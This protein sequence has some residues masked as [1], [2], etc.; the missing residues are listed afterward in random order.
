MECEEAKVRL[1][2]ELSGEL[3]KKDGESLLAHLNACRECSGEQEA[4]EWIWKE[5]EKIPDVG[6]PEG[7]RERTRSRIE[8]MLGHAPSR[9]WLRLPR[10]DWLKTPLNAVFGALAMAFL[11][12]W[13]L[14]GVTP[15]DELSAEVIFLCGA[16][17]AG[18]LAGSFLFAMGVLPAN[19]GRW[20]LASRIALTAFGLA[21]VGTL[22]CPKMSLIDWWETLPPG[23]FLLRFG[24][25]ISY[26]G[27]GL[28]YAFLPLFLAVCL[29]GRKLKKDL[30]PHAL[31]AGIVFFVLLVP[32]ILL[33]ALPLSAL[34]FFSWTVGSVLGVVIAVLSGV[35]LLRFISTT[36]FARA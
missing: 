35:E 25:G 17:L 34:V 5:L 1:I 15:L 16:V 26:A 32:A 28:L 20:R 2:A 9:V 18:L 11:A 3:S 4:L 36:R 19:G 12:L 6:V 21:M 30:L 31:S 27:F 29:L 7:L 8:R 23:E 33:Q 13:V 24:Q 22:L 10:G 14:R